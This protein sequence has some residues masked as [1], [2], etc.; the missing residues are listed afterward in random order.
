MKHCRKAV[1]K[2]DC[3]SIDFNYRR[4][5]FPLIITVI[6]VGHLSAPAQTR[7][8]GVISATADTAAGYTLFAPLMG[9]TTYLV[10]NFGRE[11]NHWTSDRTSGAT[12]YLLED[13][14][15]LRCESLQNRDF[16]GGG[17]GG[18]VKRSAWDG[19][20]MWT[21][22]YS[23]SSHCQQH[24]IEYLP[25]GN[26]LL[27]AWESKTA[28]EASARGRTATGTVWMDHVVEV[29]PS[30]SNGGEIVWEWHVWDH[31]V[32][33]KDESKENYGVVAD[34]PELIDINYSSRGG[35]M[36]SAADWLHTNAVDYNEEFDQILISVVDLSEVWIIDHST[37]KEQSASHSGGKYDRGGDLL[38]RF[39][40][41]E[42]YK[43][44]S[45]SD[46]LLYGQHGPEWIPEGL[47]G[48]GNVI[49]FNNG[50][51][52]RGSSVD[53]FKLPVDDTGKYEMGKAPEN[54]WSYTA[55]GFFATNLSNAQRLANG[56]TLICQGTNGTFYE[57]DSGKDIV[58]KYVSPVTS[59]AIKKS[60]DPGP[61]TM[62]MQ[63][64][65]C[66]RAYRYAPD[67]AAFEGKTITPP[68]AP[69]EGGT[70][71]TVKPGKT[72]VVSC[73]GKAHVSEG[74]SLSNHTNPSNPASATKINITIPQDAD[75][76]AKIYNAEGREVATLVNQYLS[77]GE[78]SYMWSTNGCAS[79]IYFVR[80]V[81]K[82]YATAHRMV[83]FQ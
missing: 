49:V 23:N 48:A 82:N 70:L 13:G 64:N 79:G 78:Y 20:V 35:G 59:N 83:L 45:S 65:Q 38:Y 62:G 22:D 27:L 42:A 50:T 71:I 11:I 25:N 75:V 53:E 4:F 56:N 31:L 26:I 72:V 15:M 54:V 73:S 52:S 40:N 68:D 33:D 76:T 7:N 63:A 14:S 51:Q 47:Q 30:G 3:S 43:S 34:H 1:K 41:P 58:W 36:M 44:G 17:S 66:F 5:C 80:L 61:G 21:Y 77:A 8:W 69:L 18:R 37:T 19:T 55:S 2:M 12:D 10:D 29:K 32:Q 60:T 28:A 81:T 67:Y 57:V 39:G 46:R 6:M 74:F 9:K 24:D 16:S